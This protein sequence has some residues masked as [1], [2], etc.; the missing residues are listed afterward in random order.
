MPPIFK[1]ICFYFQK[2]KSEDADTHAPDYDLK[3][4]VKIYL[5][6]NNME[7][8]YKDRQKENIYYPVRVTHVFSH[9]L[10]HYKKI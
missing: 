5:G 10:L 2:I 8:K 9:I 1:I 6:L 4:N 7:I 3:K